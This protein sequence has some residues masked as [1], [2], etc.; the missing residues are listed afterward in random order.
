MVLQVG[1]Y[2][3]NLALEVCKDIVK[4]LIIII[5]ITIIIMVIIIIIIIVAIFIIKVFTISV[6]DRQSVITRF[7]YFRK[8]HLSF[9]FPVFKKIGKK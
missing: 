1:G 3:V 4:I 5:I 8:D 7:T 6:I 2:V 9:Q